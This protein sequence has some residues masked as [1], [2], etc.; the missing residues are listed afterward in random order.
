MSPER[1]KQRTLSTLALAALAVAA[2]Q[3]VLAVVEDLHWIDPT[4]REAPHPHR[5]AGGDGADAGAAHRAIPVPAA[6]AAALALHPGRADPRLTRRQASEM[7]S[8]VAH[9]QTLGADVTAR[10]VARADGVPLYIE[11]PDEDG[12]GD[13]PRRRAR[14]RPAARRSSTVAR[15]PGD[16]AGLADGTSGPPGPR[17]G[18]RAALRDAGPGVLLRRMLRAVADTPEDGAARRELHKLVEAEFLHQRGG[19][20]RDVRVQARADPRGGLRQ[21]AAQRAQSGTTGASRM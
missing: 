14:E 8:R 16:A 12:G 4:T 1:Q 5:R 3:P 20:R 9:A 7:A 17:Q 6:V 11:E 10:I 13:G 21:P 19:A 18:G 2:E 15:D